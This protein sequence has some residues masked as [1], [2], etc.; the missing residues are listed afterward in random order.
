M[1]QYYNTSL[2]SDS[3]N[4]LAIYAVTDQLMKGMFSLFLISVLT[5]F[6]I[7][8][9]LKKDDTPLDAIMLGSFYGMLFSIILYVSSSFYTGMAKPGL[10]VFI[11]TI[12]FI[13]TTV[14]KFYNKK[15]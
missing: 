11:P 15:N 2:Y 5:I 7:I 13:A 12:I 8:V 6:I 4:L 10:Y 14:I 9:R 1:P 3:T